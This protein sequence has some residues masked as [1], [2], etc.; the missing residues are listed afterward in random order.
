MDALHQ[1]S[2]DLDS[3]RADTSAAHGELKA[4]HDAQRAARLASRSNNA[5]GDSLEVLEADYGTTHS[6]LDVSAELGDRIRSSSLETIANNE[7]MGDP[8]FGVIKNL[9][10][11]YRFGG[12]LMT[13]QFR[14]GDFVILPPPPEGQY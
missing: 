12:L 4:V 10:V 8:E 3:L 1:Q 13:N 6:N 5:N 11:I 14:E 9:T 7:L 2:H